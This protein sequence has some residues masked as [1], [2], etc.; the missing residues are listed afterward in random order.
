MRGTSRGDPLSPR[1]LPEPDVGTLVIAGRLT[2][3]D[4][5]ALCAQVATLLRT[6]DADVLVCD[7][8]ALERPDAATAGPLARLQLTA[9]RLGGRM[10]LRHASPELRELLALLGLDEALPA[11]GPLRVQPRRKAEEREQPGGVQERVEPGDAPV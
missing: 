1:S 11:T 10:R 6:G 2:C 4:V 8:G 5:P 3:A 9:R 7:V